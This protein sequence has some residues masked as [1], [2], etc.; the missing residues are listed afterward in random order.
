MMG[1]FLDPIWELCKQRGWPQLTVLVVNKTG[2][3]GHHLELDDPDR[4]RERV[5]DFDWFALVPPETGDFETA[6]KDRKLREL[7]AEM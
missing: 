4:E 6:I 2:L 7:C 5:Y 1:K 3:P